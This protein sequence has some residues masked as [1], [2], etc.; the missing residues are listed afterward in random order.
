MNIQETDDVL[1]QALTLLLP[2]NLGGCV[3]LDGILYIRQMESGEYAVGVNDDGEITDWEKTFVD[4]DEA[5]ELFFHT[6]NEEH[7]GMDYMIRACQEKFGTTDSTVQIIAD[8]DVSSAFDDEADVFYVT[9]NPRRKCIGVVVSPGVVVRYD[10]HYR[11]IL[12]GVTL[13]GFREYFCKRDLAAEALTW[14]LPDP[15]IHHIVK[16]A[17]Q[18]N[19]EEQAT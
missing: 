4:L 12:G 15:V 19:T 5:L 13:I 17:E 14:G 7:I 16:K 3:I 11:S 9:V 2:A 8:S 6:R 18:I 10:V 1:R